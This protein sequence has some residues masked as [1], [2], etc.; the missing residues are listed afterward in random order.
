MKR[1]LLLLIGLVPTL[2][3]SSKNAHAQT[4][5]RQIGIEINGGFMEYQGDMGSALFFSRKPIYMGM[6]GSISHYLSP[7]VDL[8][9]FGG[10]GDV[11]FYRSYPNRPEPFNEAGFRSRLFNVSLGARYKFNNDIILPVES[12]IAPYL[13]GG[14]GFQYMHSNIVNR[15]RNYTGFAGVVTLGLGV[16]YNVNETVGI[17]LQSALN[18]TFNDVWDG[19][20][21]TYGPHKVKKLEDL[22][23]FHSVGVVINLPYSIFETGPRA[24]KVLKDSD[25][26][27][28]PDKYDRCPNTPKGWEVDSV[29]CPYDTDGDG[30][31]DPMDSCVNVPGLKEFDGCPDSDGDGIPDHLDKCPD[32]PGVPENDGCPEIT[33][34]E[35]QIIDLAAK[36][37]Y[38]QINSAE[39]KPESYEKLDRLLVVLNNHPEIKIIIE[40]HT[41][42]TGDAALNKRLSQERVSSVKTYL[43]SKGIEKDRLTPIGYGEEKPMYDNNT[44]EG[45]QKNRRVYFQVVYE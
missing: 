20:P 15:P 14:W 40:G 22:Y 1:K 26:D 32:I 11:G 2:M 39:L 30:V 17:R 7:S 34:E 45:R 43:V 16:Q 36:G 31:Y 44:E 33:E 21:F 10:S 3:L 19:E 38:F 23:M 25:G 27:G 41:D 4:E 6:G 9:L 5:D 13:I 28:V 42:N 29:G 24:P 18:Y 37:V 12:I 35:K 8:M